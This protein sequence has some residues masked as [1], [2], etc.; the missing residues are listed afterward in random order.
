[1]NLLEDLISSSLTAFINMK[2]GISLSY[3]FTSFVLGMMRVNREH[4]NTKK[5]PNPWTE[6]FRKRYRTVEVRALER[7]W[8][9]SQK[10]HSFTLVCSKAA[11]KSFVIE[12]RRQCSWV[13]GELSE[14]L[15]NPCVN[16]S[17]LPFFA[18]P[19]L[20]LARCSFF[21]GYKQ[22]MTVNLSAPTE[23]AHTKDHI[24]IDKTSLTDPVAFTNHNTEFS[25]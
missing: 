25:C 9:F 15:W 12:G 17:P 3:C 11:D 1:M 24:N 20:S 19:A 6:V 14:N 23:L 22:G 13:S 4:T 18:A 5:N 8:N 10:V 2:P 21:Q 16:P 7:P